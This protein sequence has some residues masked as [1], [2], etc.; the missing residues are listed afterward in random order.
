MQKKVNNS[1][2]SLL[3]ADESKNNMAAIAISTISK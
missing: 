1:I 3:I 2:I